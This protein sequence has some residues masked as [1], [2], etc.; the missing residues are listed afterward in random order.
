MTLLSAEQVATWRGERDQ[1][2]QLLGQTPGHVHLVGIGGIG[3]AGVARHLAHRGF[4]VSGSDEVESRVTEWLRGHGIT[5]TC[6]HAADQLG[7]HVQWVIKTP[8]VSD[9]NPELVA[10]RERGLPVFRRGAALPALL[11]GSHSVAVSGTH[12]KTTTSAMIAHILQHAGRDPSFCIGGEL[13][14]LGGVAGVGKGEAFV[15]EADESDGTVVLY[16]PDIAVVTNVEYD[17]M[18]HFPDEESFVDCF[19]RFISQARKSVVVCADDPIA[20]SLA[21]GA[22]TFGFSESAMVRGTHFEP[23]G[24]RCGFQI[25]WGDGAGTDVELPVPGNHNAVNAVGA[26]TAARELGVEPAAIADALACFQPARRR[27]EQVWADDDVRV[28]SDYAHHPTEVRAVIQTARQLGGRRVRAIYQP[29]RYTRTLALR[30]QF[31]P[32]FDGLDELI[33]VPVYAASEAPIVGATSEDLLQAVN[34]RGSII[35][36]FEQDLRVAWDRLR[37][38]AEPGDI[39]LILGAGD[40]ERIVD[41]A[42]R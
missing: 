32:A 12:G 40:V 25:R 10:A 7:A 16:E 1:I 41:W 35:A 13:E 39:L 4:T 8:A 36:S 30:D 15:V 29:H 20:A 27:F 19:R 5:V 33:L 17:H 42:R 22:T 24:D 6:G 11:R 38:S 3:M 26:A 28:I 21:P 2:V 18:E 14:Q 31:P 37:G 9:S 23:A 34:K